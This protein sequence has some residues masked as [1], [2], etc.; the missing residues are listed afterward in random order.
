MRA[1]LPKQ[2]SQ[3]KD[4]PR[5]FSRGSLL[6]QGGLEQGPQQGRSLLQR[7][8]RQKPLRVQEEPEP[9]RRPQLEELKQVTL[10]PP[11]LSPPKNV[12]T[13]TLVHQLASRGITGQHLPAGRLLYYL[14]NWKSLTGDQ[15]VLHTV[16]GYQLELQYQL[17]LLQEPFRLQ[18][19]THHS[20]LRSRANS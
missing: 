10:P 8:Q 6:E 17:E 2:Q 7:V 4:S 5:F 13:G 20:T 18:C 11:Q 19:H 1:T 15:W 12:V 9:G 3:Q 16:Q 14:E